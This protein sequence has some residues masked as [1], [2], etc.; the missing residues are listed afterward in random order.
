MLPQCSFRLAGVTTLLLA[1]A[2]PLSAQEP[3]Q[4]K[5]VPDAK[6]LSKAEATITKLFAAKFK[7]AK[8]NKTVAQALANELLAQGK[9]TKD[10]DK[11][12]I[13]GPEIGQRTGRPRRRPH[14]RAGGHRGTG[15]SFKTDTLDLKSWHFR[16]GRKSHDQQG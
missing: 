8:T 10:D 3:V 14:H 1:L 11:L 2:L 7:E 16:P 13:R 15:Q 4:R 6:T 5:T 9:A 12:A